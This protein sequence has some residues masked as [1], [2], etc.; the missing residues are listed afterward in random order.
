[1][2]FVVPLAPAGSLGDY[3]PF[4]FAP[5]SPMLYTISRGNVPEYQEGQEPVVHLVS[6]MDDVRSFQPPLQ[7][8]FTDGHA[9]I[10]LSNYYNHAADLDKIDWDIMERRYWADTVEDG[11]RERRRQAEFLIY[12][13]FP[14]RLI[15][16]IG[17]MNQRTR[18][19]VTTILALSE[20]KPT[21]AV[22]QGWYY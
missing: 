20:H 12:Q 10:E 9:V 2:R 22:E 18:E 16:K 17:V 8:L 3:V 13:F 6:S 1:M 4:Y 21:V 15:S 14:W 19:R 7:W 11:D 5:R